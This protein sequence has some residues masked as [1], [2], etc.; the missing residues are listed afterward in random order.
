MMKTLRTLCLI[1]LALFSI[2]SAYAN[3]DAPII[4]ADSWL[5]MSAETGE[6]LAAKDAEKQIEPASLVK[7]MTAYLIARSTALGYIKNDD[8]VMIDK[9]AWAFANPILKG[10]PLMF[11]KADEVVA[12]GDLKKGLIIQSGNDAAIA[13]AKYMATSQDAFIE[14]MNKTAHEMG[15]LYSDFKNVHGLNIEGQQTSALDMA[16]LARRLIKDTPEDYALYKSSSFSHNGIKQF[17]RNKLIYQ[18]KFDVDGL[19][20]GTTS[21]NKYHIVTS[22]ESNGVRYIAVIL[23]ADTSLARFN[24]A[25]KLLAWGFEHYSLYKPDLSFKNALPVRVWYGDKSTIHVNY[26][27]N[28]AIDVK[29]SELDK[30]KI[31]PVFNEAYLSAPIKKGQ[32]IGY[33]EFIVNNETIATR[34]LVALDEVE[35]GNIFT[36]IWDFIL[37]TLDKIFLDIKNIINSK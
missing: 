7:L 16:I 18:S 6:V 20:T 8:K 1:S 10:S 19:I 35:E 37:Q 11:L 26:P 13:L 33:S 34:E 9:E 17:N 22:A 31:N 3:N 15:M 4:S 2:S 28:T 24:E 14:Q 12:I 36:K 30:V 5:L 23:N 32:V 29:S 21:A 27:E 25:D